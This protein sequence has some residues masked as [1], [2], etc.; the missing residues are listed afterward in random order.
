MGTEAGS[1]WDWRDAELMDGLPIHIAQDGLR[2]EPQ[3]EAGNTRA[4]HRHIRCRWRRDGDRV[5]GIEL[6]HPDGVAERIGFA[7]DNVYADFEDAVGF[8][9]GAGCVSVKHHYLM[10]R[11][12]LFEQKS[13]GVIT[14]R[15][16]TSYL[17]SDVGQCPAIERQ[18]LTRKS[19]NAGSC[20]QSWQ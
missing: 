16:L 9:A 14:A 6:R 20:L 2:W 12:N 8:A 7:F 5:S 18:D 1:S 4:R 19:S 13:S 15:T 11:R 3:L 10:A 17:N